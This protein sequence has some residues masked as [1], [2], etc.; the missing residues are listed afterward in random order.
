M[1]ATPD[2]MWRKTGKARDLQ[3]KSN[4]KKLTTSHLVHTILTCL[5]RF[6]RTWRLT[7][8]WAKWS[9]MM[10]NVGNL[11]IPI[12]SINTV[13]YNNSKYIDCTRMGFKSATC[14]L[15]TQLCQ[16]PSFGT[17][18]LQ[19][20]VARHHA[21]M[22]IVYLKKPA[23]Q[24]FTDS[25]HLLSHPISTYHGDVLPAFTRWRMWRRWDRWVWLLRFWTCR[26]SPH[27]WH[28]R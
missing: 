10:P 28:P 16:V 15:G 4:S 14:K 5:Q 23:F 22:S 3:C 12:I 9:Q 1:Q 25:S 2:P 24:A 18:L 7:K 26:S 13:S 6:G 8:K 21:S 27:G 20:S 19:I 11:S 17:Q